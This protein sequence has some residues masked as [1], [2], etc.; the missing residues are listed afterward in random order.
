MYRTFLISLLVL[1]SCK[2]FNP[3]DPLPYSP[4]KAPEWKENNKLQQAEILAKG[5]V[6]GPEDV[7]IDKSGNLYASSSKGIIYFITKN[8]EVS[9]FAETGGRPLGLQLNE[10][11]DTLYVCDA[12]KGLLSVSMTGLVTVLATESNGTPFRF[13]DD[14]DI[15][16]S[17]KIY[18]TDASS[19]YQQSEYLY[20]LLETR[21]RGRLMEYDIKTKSTRTI[22]YN[23][24]FAN[25]V[26]LSQNEDFVLVNE[27][28]R[29]RITRYWLKGPKQGTADTFM[30]NLPG[31]P[32]NIS[33][34]RKGKFWLALFTVRNK[35]MDDMHPSP[36]IKKMISNLPKMF[37]P[38]PKPHGFVLGINEK[39]IIENDFQ[40]PSGETL[41]EIT[42]A[43]EKNGY[44]YLGSL[45]GVKIGRYK[46]P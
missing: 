33:S 37:W 23:L 3:I 14:L 5:L 19:K 16:K 42:S 29:Y 35:Q 46:L 43:N 9:S 32:D 8:G 20:D 41:K 17:G 31:F 15:S 22:L 28:Y 25:G 11:E 40:D 21:P 24:Y 2:I 6:D 45:H 7:A 38:K 36:G 39:G 13:T 44:L 4:K 18:F 10:A 30:D 12:Y 1:A 34:N 27:T 26:A